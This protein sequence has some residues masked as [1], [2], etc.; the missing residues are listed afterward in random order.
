[1]DVPYGKHRRKLLLDW[2]ETGNVDDLR[3]IPVNHKW[4]FQTN[5]P[6]IQYLIKKGCLKYYRPSAASYKK[7]SSTCRQTYLI[8]K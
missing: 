3:G 8:K 4:Q 7:K 5:D 2:F 1:M 6:D